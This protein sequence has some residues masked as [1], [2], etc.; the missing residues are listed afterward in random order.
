MTSDRTP[1]PI[2]TQCLT[3]LILSSAGI[4]SLLVREHRGYTL[5]IARRQNNQR[6]LF[7]HTQSDAHS[8]TRTPGADR[9]T[10]VKFKRYM[11]FLVAWLALKLVGLPHLVLREGSPQEA[12]LH[13]HQD[14]GG[15][16]PED[17]LELKRRRCRRG[18]LLPSSIHQG[19]GGRSWIWFLSVTPIKCSIGLNDCFSCLLLMLNSFHFM[20]EFMRRT[21]FLR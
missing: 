3:E 4:F 14:C 10:A 12:G 8:R 21:V 11:L 9:D 1:S 2:R 13:P 7:T 20:C 15:R 5:I 6:R 18:N 16:G 17:R 19:R